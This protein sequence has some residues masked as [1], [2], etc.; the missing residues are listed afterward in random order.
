MTLSDISIKRPVLASVF[1]IAIVIFGLVAFFS[2]GVREYP[3]VD[4][5]IITVRTDYTGANAQII[6]SQITEPLEESVNRVDGIKRISSISSTGRS[7]IT[8]EFELG[9][10]LDN[11]ANDVRDRVAQAVRN[12]PPD[13]DPPIVSKADAD[14]QTIYTVTLS[15]DQRSLLEL[16]EIADNVFAERLQTIEGVSQINI[17]GQKRY[18][19]RL[20]LDVEKMDA[21]NITPADI[22]N[23]LS[24]QNV[25]LPSGQIEGDRT[26]ITIQTYGRLNTEE[27]YDNL[28]I[29]RRD[30]TLIRLQDVGRAVLGA[31]N[32]KSILRGNNAIPMVGVAMQPQPGSN[33]IE[34]VDEAQRRVKQMQL[35]I[36]D[37]I[38]IGVG[39]DITNSIRRSIRDVQYTIIVAFLLVL[40]IIFVFL[41][42]FRT[43]FIPIITIPISLLGSFA[44]LYM[45]GF[46]I[47]VLTLL[48]L[49]LA[50]GLVVDDAIVMMENIYAKIEQGMNPI[51]AAF[52]GAR[53]VFFAI[54]ATTVTLISVFLPIFFMQG[55]T[56]RLFRE[57]AMVVSGAVIISTFISLTFTV[58]LSSR[59]LTKSKQEYRSL[60]YVRMPIDYVLTRYPGWLKRFMRFRV[61]SFPAVA[62]MAVGVYLLF[63]NLPTE[64]APLDDKSAMTIISTAPEGLSYEMMDAYQLQLIEL[65]DTL[66]EVEYLLS[67]TSPGFGASV[68]VNSGFIRLMLAPPNER[69]KTQMDLANELRPLLARYNLANSFVVQQ[70]TISGGSGGGRALPVQYVLQAPNL[71]KLEEFLPE[72]LNEARQ[73]PA[74]DVVDVDLRFTKPEL[75]LDIDR[76]KAFDMGISVRDIAETLQT[77]FSEQRVG[78]FIRD[79]KQYFVIAQAERHQRGT[80]ESISD[81]RVRTASGAMVSL[82]NV[83]RFRQESLPPQLLRFN[84]YSSATISAST[85]SGYTLGDGI[86]AMDEIAARVLDESF[87][88]ALTGTSADYAESAD[89]LLLVFVFALILIYL[90][91][92]AQFESFRDP[93]TIMFTVPLALTGALLSL[94]VFG[95]TINIFSQI[96]MIVLVGI[97]TKNGILIVEFANQKRLE[98]ME[99]MEAVMEAAAERIRPIIMT[100]L[101]T[102]L[103]ALPLV[104]SL[105]GT[106]NSRVPMGVVIIGGLLFSLVLTLFIIPALYTFIASKKK[107]FVTEEEQETP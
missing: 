47:N 23:A 52:K 5:P 78:F 75:V 55:L 42:S 4:P 67:V 28:I 71:Q 98:G 100:S 106:S 77:Y 18:A 104:I 34:I 1:A 58:M 12:L 50:T 11:A 38:T 69:G 72:F 95:Q 2:L 26:Y 61:W 86:D 27:E 105:G 25:E 81:I 17:W 76:E 36:P 6:E 82:E 60:R 94:W 91:L 13:A 66:P 16:T 99:R 103:G 73:H 3:S 15:S 87:F 35:E 101:A 46:S 62:V 9:R 90:T 45:A 32:E 64:L 93:L 84:R 96:G 92:A 43:T 37:D 70:P 33:F 83:V 80:P 14:A 88:T 49:L 97:V 65:L 89:N 85:A 44:F 107:T 102:A 20:I 56:G 22:R 53:Q 48:G 31:Q 74:F 79:G 24:S 8:V 10:N 7:T 21:F 51:Q 54:I 30:N 41:R 40:L 39:L 57:F 59:M 19:M 68:S 63:N 29:A